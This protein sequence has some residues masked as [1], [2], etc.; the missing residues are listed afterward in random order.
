MAQTPVW[1]QSIR[2]STP[3]AVRTLRNVRALIP[4]KPGV[5]VFTKHNHPTLIPGHG[6]LYIGIAE[7]ALSQ[8]FRKYLGDPAK[9]KILGRSGN[10]STNLKHQAQV[11]LLLETMHGDIGGLDTVWV[12]WFPYAKAA[13]IEGALMDYL[14]PGFNVRTEQIKLGRSDPLP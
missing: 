9:I 10:I 5:Y 1:F 3:I 11:Q 2:W 6:I 14:Q 13:L 12:R 8:R 7:T 4:N